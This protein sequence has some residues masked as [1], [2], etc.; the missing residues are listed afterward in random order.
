VTKTIPIEV[1]VGRL[2]EDGVFTRKFADERISS[3]RDTERE[4]ALLIALENAS[5]EG[6]AIGLL[7]YEW[8]VL[9][10]FKSKITILTPAGVREFE[11]TE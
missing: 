10:D 2:I 9:P 11:Y 6:G 3:K 1:I 7:H 8:S 4:D 5:Q